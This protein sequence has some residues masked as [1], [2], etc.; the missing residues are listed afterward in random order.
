MRLGFWQSIIVESSGASR[1]LCFMWTEE[2]VMVP[3]L[4]SSHHIDTEVEVLEV[5]G[6]W[7]LTR[8][9]GYPVIADRHKSW[10][11]LASLGDAFSMAWLGGSVRND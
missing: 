5:P 3:R 4:F 7:R 11:L 6:R 1:G 9:Y 10:E 8:F 2:V